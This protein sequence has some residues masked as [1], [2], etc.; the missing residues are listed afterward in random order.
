V[1]TVQYI[2]VFAKTKSMKDITNLIKKVQDEDSRNVRGRSN[3]TKE[4]LKGLDDNVKELAGAGFI[5]KDVD[6]L[7]NYNTKTEEAAIYAT[8]QQLGGYYTKEQTDQMLAAL[9]GG[10]YVVSYDGTSAPTI[11]NIPAGVTV[12]YDGNTYTGTLA[13]SASTKDNIYL[14][15]QDMYITSYDGTDYSWIF[16]GTTELDLS[17]YAT[18]AKISQ[19]EAEVGD[20]PEMEYGNINSSG[21]EVA[22]TSY[23]R[24]K[25]YLEAPFGF[26]VASGMIVGNIAKYTKSG[27][28]YTFVSAQSVSNKQQV[29]ISNTSFYYR[30]VVNHNGQTPASAQEVFLS[31]NPKSFIKRDDVLRDDEFAVRNIL[32]NLPVSEIAVSPGTTTTGLMPRNSITGEISANTSTYHSELIEIDNNKTYFVKTKIYEQYDAGVAYYKG[33]VVSIENFCG[34][35]NAFVGDG[36]TAEQSTKEA[37]LSIPASAKYFIVFTRNT[38][39]WIIKARTQAKTASTDDLSGKV[40]KIPGKGL[41]TNDF[42]NEDKNKLDSLEPGGVPEQVVEQAVNDYVEEHSAGFVPQIKGV[43]VLPTYEYKLMPSVLSEI[44]PGTGWSGDL[45]NGYT[46]TS[47]NTDPLV[48]PLSS[49]TNGKKVLISFN[50]TGVTSESTDLLVSHGDSYGIKT[51]NGGSSFVAGFVQDGTDLKITPAS[52]YSG[53]ITNLKARVIDFDNGTETLSVT[54][55]SVYNLRNALVAGFWNIVVGV[56]DG[57]MGKAQDVTRTIAIGDHALYDIL[58][59]NRNVAIGTF[60]MA[61]VKDGENNVSIGADTIYPILHANNCVA[62]GKATL[63]GKDATDCVAIGLGAMGSWNNTWERERCV[64][65]GRGAGPAIISE[66]THIGYRAGANVSGV[67]NTSV[68]FNALGIGNRSTIDI[69]GTKLTCIGYNASVANDETAKAAEN[70]TAIGA[71]ATITKSNQVVIG[72][73]N[74]T[75]FVFGGKK[76]VFNND[77]TISWETVS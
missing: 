34:I 7:T 36:V 66:C 45:E 44:T 10:S 21:T 77:N 58:F 60:A 57:T 53:T 69:I 54:Q 63:T 40:D 4:I 18:E 39:E 31:F 9:G 32:P 27:D 52:N 17:N 65:I 23:S 33:N 67:K 20:I 50:A 35:D 48:F 11:A 56:G 59:G 46:H 19:L 29:Y 41:S 72:D 47:G 30:F 61:F 13:A 76:I 5:T 3:Q 70:S 14:V 62:I 12:T 73:A 6:N 43:N 1:F 75:E 55:N 42:S 49:I 16:A 28:T 74:V 2:S 15:G 8:K 64:A 38:S 26:K 71:N 22:S 25:T 37:L 24:T 51:Y 68:G